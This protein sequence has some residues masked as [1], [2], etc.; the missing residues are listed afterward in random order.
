MAEADAFRASGGPLWDVEAFVCCVEEACRSSGPVPSEQDLGRLPGLRDACA[1]RGAV[2]EE[3]Q[4]LRS[5]AYRLWRA[6][7]APGC[8]ALAGLAEA[9]LRQFA[10]ELHAACRPSASGSAE[11]AG[12]AAAAQLPFLAPAEGGRDE[13][14]T[15]AAQWALAGRAWAAAGRADSAIRCFEAAAQAWEAAAPDAAAL[16]SPGVTKLAEAA[17]QAHV[18]ASAVH[19]GTQSHSLS[20]AALARAKDA[21]SF[22]S[23]GEGVLE[24]FL[25]TCCQQ[26][27]EVQSAGRPQQ[28]IELL[29]LALATVPAEEAED[30]SRRQG[31]A[32]AAM[33]ARL[34]RHL[35]LCYG[36]LPER[37]RALEH[38]RAAVQEED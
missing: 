29:T 32:A 17:M 2:G 18:W 1:A 27:S 33:R 20:M 10:C 37:G 12:L 26:A 8:E 22:C 11:M 23:P 31:S 35:A 38:A 14:A 25:R 34:L 5:L 19:F 28:A 30:G 13:E 6:C 9:R 15:L 36:R 7:A 16:G 4:R 21:L 3:L 24:D